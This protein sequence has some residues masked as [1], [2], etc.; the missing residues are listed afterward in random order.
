MTE[1]QS[2]PA[3]EAF[4]SIASH[5]LRGGAYTV[6]SMISQLDMG[7]KGETLSPRQRRVLSVATDGAL[8]LQQVVKDLELVMKR[9]DDTLWTEC[10][11]MPLR[12]LI[13][14]AIERAQQPVAPDAPRTISVSVHSGA[15][16]CYGDRSLAARAL[17]TGPT[18]S[19]WVLMARLAASGAQFVSI[20]ETLSE[21]VGRPASVALSPAEGLAVLEAFEQGDTEVLDGLP[22]LTAT[23]AAT[24]AAL[25]TA[26][27]S[28]GVAP[29]SV[30]R[31]LRILRRQLR[32]IRQATLG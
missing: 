4:S 17:A 26:R 8:R 24:V 15:A 7:V 25:E 5:A 14:G 2:S 13:A 10:E 16:R 29:A 9:A 21:Q 30:P 19:D 1:P 27:Q 3:K 31:A 11:V 23:L 6:V 12:T 18:D 22:L 32:A 28:D 20:P